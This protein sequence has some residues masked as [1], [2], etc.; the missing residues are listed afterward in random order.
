MTSRFRL[1]CPLNTI[2]VF[3][4]KHH[5]PCCSDAPTCY[6]SSER[7]LVAIFL[8][9]QS[10]VLFCC[11]TWFMSNGSM[12]HGFLKPLL[13]GLHCHCSSVWDMIDHGSL[14]LLTDV[15]R[16]NFMDQYRP[17][18][19]SILSQRGP[20]TWSLV[21][22]SHHHGILNSYFCIPACYPAYLALPPCPPALISVPL[23]K[24]SRHI[25]SIGRSLQSRAALY[26]VGIWTGS[27]QRA[28]RFAHFLQGL[29]EGHGKELLP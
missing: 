21:H 14:L 18:A 28:P 2:T 6:S 9:C 10:H 26:H 1:R 20:W 23:L 4:L 17:R 3:L 19:H 11:S 29:G 13:H 5:T 24:G 12:S 15:S 8:V 7:A 16:A 22:G 25:T 27:W